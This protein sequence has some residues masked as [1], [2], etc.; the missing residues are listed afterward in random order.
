MQ[1]VL[2]FTRNASEP[3]NAAIAT[4]AFQSGNGAVM[5]LVAPTR[6]IIFVEPRRAGSRQCGGCRMRRG[7]QV[8]RPV[9]IRQRGHRSYPFDVITEPLRRAT[10][11]TRAPTLLFRPDKHY[12]GLRRGRGLAGPVCNSRYVSSASF[13]RLGSL[14]ATLQTPVTTENAA[15]SFAGVSFR[16]PICGVRSQSYKA[17]SRNIRCSGVASRYSRSSGCG[18]CRNKFMPTSTA[19]TPQTTHPA[20]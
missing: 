18:F 14:P 20:V 16:P 4:F 13:S 2:V 5:L 11:L 10:S 3:E 8:R 7:K 6:T 19:G 12:P 15:A 17:R 9:K 1:G